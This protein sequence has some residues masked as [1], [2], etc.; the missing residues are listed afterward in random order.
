MTAVVIGGG[1]GG[2]AIAAELCE[3]GHE[4]YIADVPEL[5]FQLDAIRQQAGIGLDSN[6]SGDFIRPVTVADSIAAAVANAELVV[7][8]VP[9]RFHER[10]VG[11]VVPHLRQE[12]TWIFVGEGGGTLVAWPEL[13]KADRSDVLLGETN[14]LPYMAR[15]AGPG[16]VL[17]NR[18]SGGVLL[19]AMPATRNEQLM[20][21]CLSIWPYVEAAETVWE[22]A[23]I[24]YD[25]IDTVPVAITSAARLESRS[26]GVLFWG[27]G[28]TPSV[29]RLI[30][31]V[32]SE[33][34]TLR[35]ALGHAD[36]RRYRD[37]LVA[38][39]L[40]P[41]V[42]D[43]YAVMR[44]GS[45]VRSVRPSGDDAALRDRLALEVAYC[46]V[47]ASSLGEAIG[48]ATPVIDGHIAIAEAMLAEDFRGL[49]RTLNRLGLSGLNGSGLVEYV[50]S[51]YTAE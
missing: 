2:L 20:A 16:R 48:V 32:D 38:Q 7:I 25:A 42:G 5:S 26:G 4:V 43:L 51:G 50:R 47:L 36:R 45:L 11:E 24:N 37:F 39:G 17:A 23:L 33:L 22:T 31:A 41:D 6:W 44:A 14:C 10:F 3:R 29:V 49:G 40:A 28:A 8:C 18:K 46:L 1:P 27:E 12:A 34:A 19:A 21:I 13:L 15:R 9:A 30:D 35:E